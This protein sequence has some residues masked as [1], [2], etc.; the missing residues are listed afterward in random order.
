MCVDQPSF[1]FHTIENGFLFMMLF[2]ELVLRIT[3]YQEWN[4]TNYA[5]IYNYTP[6]ITY[7]CAF[8]AFMNQ[9][10]AISSFI[11]VMMLFVGE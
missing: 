5:D 6:Q 9:F 8:N 3:W 4:D 7:Y 10:K 2:G 1:V 11:C